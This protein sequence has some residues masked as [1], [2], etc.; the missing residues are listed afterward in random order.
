MK[1]KQNDVVVLKTPAWPLNEWTIFYVANQVC[2]LIEDPME[3]V[4][5]TKIE[6]FDGSHYID[7]SVNKKDLIKIGTI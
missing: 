3:I 4:I 1:F 5:I 2:F 6:E 7:I